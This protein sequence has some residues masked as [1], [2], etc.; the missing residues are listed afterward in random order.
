MRPDRN[1]KHVDAGSKCHT[2]HRKMSSD[3][4]FDLTQLKVNV[5]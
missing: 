2:Q 5:H 3:A 1:Q 4:G